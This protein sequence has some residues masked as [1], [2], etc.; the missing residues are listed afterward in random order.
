MSLELPSHPSLDHLK[1]QARRR[2][3]KLRLEN[4]AATL[5]DALHETARDYGF[6]TWPQLKTHVVSLAP[7]PVNPFAGRWIANVD[8]SERHPLNEFQ[9]A[10]LEFEVA[11]DLVTIRHVAVET[12]GRE[13]RDTTIVLVD[14]QEHVVDRHGNGYVARWLAP[15][16]LDVEARKYD[17][18]VG[19]GTYE[20]SADGRTMTVSTAEQRIVL[21]RSERQRAIRRPV[22]PT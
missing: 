17:R 19:R 16:V 2:L 22:G 7:A 10:T 3:S 18:T 6:S 15:S 5:A 9:Q 20:V 4:P 14:G 21:D 11:G 8:K 13:E 1:K 12:S